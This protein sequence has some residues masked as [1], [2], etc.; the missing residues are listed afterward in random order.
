MKIKTFGINLAKAVF[1][2]GLDERG[3]LVLGT[4]TCPST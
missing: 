2:V 3:H 4:V 1:Q